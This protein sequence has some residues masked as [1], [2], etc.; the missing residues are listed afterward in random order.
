MNSWE[1]GVWTFA[2][3]LFLLCWLFD[4]RKHVATVTG[5]RRTKLEETLDKPVLGQA[6]VV[7]DNSTDSD[8]QRQDD[9]ASDEYPHGGPAA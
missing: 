4:V 5:K 3:I 8:E 6:T 1:V 7:D 9:P 2:G